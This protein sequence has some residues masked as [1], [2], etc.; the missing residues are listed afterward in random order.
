MLAVGA[1]IGVIAGVLR[2]VAA[3][4][5][6]DDFL[7]FPVPTWLKVASGFEVLAWVF[8]AAAFGTA[9][10][11]FFL[12]SHRTRATVLA[13][14][15]G[16]FAGYGVSLLVN[17]LI[18]LVQEWSFSEPWTFKASGF[19][20][21]AAGLS[22]AVAGVLVAIGLL[23]SRPDGR[24]GW[25]AIGLAG[26]FG[27]LATA[28]SF[29]LAELLTFRFG[30]ISAEIKWGLGTHAG[31]QL[32]VAAGAAVAAAAFFT[33]SGRRERAESWQ[34]QREGSLGIA[35][36]VFT[37]G[38]LVGAVG[39]VLLASHTGD[40]GRRVAEYWLQVG[41]EFLLAGVAAC[42]VVGFFLS[43]RGLEQRDGP[44]TAA[45]ADPG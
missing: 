39:L 44:D 45:F 27:L 40:T 37:I 25:G 20:V 29:E 38:F 3:S 36:I 11:G 1:A 7:S 32:I 8:V 5:S 23:S 42:G 18:E 6:L 9:L 17:A 16:L 4:L 28:F 13:V 12:R 26:H 41:A 34:A 10:V 22:V 43:R 31:G 15:A 35:A 19:A 33:S 14:S 2:V 21:A 30:P 24:L